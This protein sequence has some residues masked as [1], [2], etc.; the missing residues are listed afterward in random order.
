MQTQLLE[1][2]SKPNA[3]VHTVAKYFHGILKETDF[4][5]SSIIFW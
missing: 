1:I 3:K 2:Q 4:L 5:E